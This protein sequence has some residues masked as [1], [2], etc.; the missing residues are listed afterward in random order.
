M[1]LWRAVGSALLR[2]PRA[3]G[4]SPAKLLFASIARP[5]EAP[6]QYV[7]RFRRAT[8]PGRRRRSG[9]RPVRRTGG[10][11]SLCLAPADRAAVHDP[12]PCVRHLSPI[13]WA[14]VVLR[15]SAA[16]VAISDHAS[17][18]VM[19]RWGVPST[20]IRVGISPTA[21]P[22]RDARSPSR[23]F[24]L[25][26]VG[27]LEPKKG[28]DLLIR[29]VRHLNRSAELVAL[30]IYGGGSQ[31]EALLTLADAS[32]G[33]GGLVESQ[34]MRDIYR[35]YDAFALAAR[36]AVTVTWTAFRWCS[37]RQASPAC[38]SSPRPSPASPS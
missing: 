35:E 21:V 29:A 18:Q 2:H 37:W 3:L 5:R 36:V 32:I 10:G 14:G 11:R 17:S 22:R 8:S 15:S 19:R 12:G 24:K 13:S 7:P 33:F 25:I 30:D 16:V 23:P 4:G 34:R 26:S 38:P 1:A 31:R 6:W 9:A 27:A 28:H 20:V